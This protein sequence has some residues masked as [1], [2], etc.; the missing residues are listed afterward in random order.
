MTFKGDT[1]IGEPTMSLIEI[2][3]AEEG[4]YCEPQQVYDYWKKKDWTTKKGSEVKTLE[5]A[6]NVVNSIIVERAVRQI[7]KERG[8][9]RM[10]K[11]AKNLVRN[12]IKSQIQSGSIP[13]EKVLE[14]QVNRK[15]RKKPK[16]VYTAYADQL[17]DNRWYAFRR[18][19]FE[20]RGKRCERCGADSDLQV[21]HKQYKK[22]CL[23]WEYTCKD[24]I[25]LCRDCHMKIHGIEDKENT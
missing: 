22:G 3:I 5:A 6:C 18:F 21:H 16:R 13:K 19:I 9:T 23:A 20:V 17:N 1:I 15:V 10:S 25:V 7:A 14:S 12:T 4:L 2:C 11:K 8:T 24:V